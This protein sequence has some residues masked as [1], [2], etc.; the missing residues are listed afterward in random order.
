MDEGFWQRRWA[1]NEIGFHLTEVNP[2]LRR[3]WSALRLAKGTRVLVP[4][5]GK[6]LDMVWLAEQ[7]FAVHGIELSERAVED[8]FVEQNLDAEVSVQGRFKVYRAAALKIFCGDF[9]ALSRSDVADC[10]GF[11]DRDAL[12][13]L[14]ADMRQRYVEHMADILA[15]SSQG[16][17]V[18]LDYEQEQMSGPPFG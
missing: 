15:P 14:P 1:R 7:G 6:S 2:Y 13:A 11:Y 17:L 3:Y 8:F 16:L 18:T 12:I 10:Q 5:C 4:L 9:F